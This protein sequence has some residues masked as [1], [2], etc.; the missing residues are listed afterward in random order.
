VHQSDSPM[1][2]HHRLLN[3]LQNI[4]LIADNC[5]AIWPQN[6]VYLQY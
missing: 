1:Q 3:L 6:T 2:W 5:P 4:C